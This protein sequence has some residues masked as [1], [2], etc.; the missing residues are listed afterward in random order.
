LSFGEPPSRDLPEIGAGSKP[1]EDRFLVLAYLPSD[2]SPESKTR[3]T[4]TSSWRVGTSMLSRSV[5]TFFQTLTSRLALAGCCD[6]CGELFLG[7]PLPERGGTFGN[8]VGALLVFHSSLLA[9]VGTS[10]NSGLQ[11]C[12]LGLPP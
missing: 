6:E 8:P 4:K 12:T 10:V 7:A 1:S 11:V 3:S 2:A 5:L 9:L